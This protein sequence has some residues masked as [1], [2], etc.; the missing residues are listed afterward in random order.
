M[1]M[2]RFRQIVT[3]CSLGGCPTITRDVSTGDFVVVGKVDKDVANN[4]MIRAKVN[5][6]EMAVV[7]PAELFISFM[8]ALVKKAA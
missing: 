5:E 6:G 2:E 7:V 1:F 4:P 8:T 3:L